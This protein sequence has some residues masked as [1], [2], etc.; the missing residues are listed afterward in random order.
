MEFRFPE[1]RIWGD[2]ID[3]FV[4]AKS[5]QNHIDFKKCKKQLILIDFAFS[6]DATDASSMHDLCT[7]FVPESFKSPMIFVEFGSARG[8][9]FSWSYR[10]SCR[11]K[12][13]SVSKNATKTNCL[14]SICF[15]GAIEFYRTYTSSAF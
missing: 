4:V 1:G 8:P 11:R 7:V 2:L 10:S 13:T 15:P 5:L 3:R 6:T 9:D 12:V 14:S